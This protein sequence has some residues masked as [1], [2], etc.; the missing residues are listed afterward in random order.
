M[1]GIDL[2]LA[3]SLSSILKKQIDKK[4][5][6]KFERRLFEKHGMSIKQSIEHFQ[7]FDLTLK[8]FIGNEAENL[9]KKCLQKVCTAEKSKRKNCYLI[10]IK[11]QNLAKFVLDCWGND[12]AR[13]ILNV[14]LDK[15]VT[16]S[17]I[18]TV[19]DMT[20]TSGY[21]KIDS[22][23]RNGMFVTHSIVKS[24]S[25]KVPKYKSIF[26]NVT[27]KIDKDKIVIKGRINKKYFEASSV[28]QILL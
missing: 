18:L 4:I 25:K 26:D 19:C 16:I 11:E 22:L 28:A 15:P 12:E 5:L 14:G 6:K 10:T 27:I 8:E 7:K 13:K 24:R 3:K 23:V 9:E 1:P 20:K 2:L 21:R 17:Q